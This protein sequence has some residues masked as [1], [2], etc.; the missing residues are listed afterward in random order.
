MSEFR[1]PRQEPYFSTYQPDKK[2]AL[3]LGA[4]LD[5]LL[6]INTPKPRLIDR[7]RKAFTRA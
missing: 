3:L 6:K 1:D 4:I 5:Q 7:I 2:S